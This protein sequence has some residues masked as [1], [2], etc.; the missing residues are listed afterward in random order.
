MRLTR[1]GRYA[2]GF[3]AMAMGGL[4]GLLTANW[5]WYGYCGP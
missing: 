1:R 3:T 5:C 4:I 2:L